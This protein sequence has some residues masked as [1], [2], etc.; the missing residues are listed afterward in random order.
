MTKARI[1][2]FILLSFAGGIA[3]RSFIEIPYAVLLLVFIVGFLAILAG[4]LRQKRQLWA[5][6]LMVLAVL[7]GIVRYDF[8]DYSQPVLGGL[9][10]KS[11]ILEGYVLREPAQSDKALNFSFRV[12]SLEGTRL[13]RPFLVRVTTRRFPEYAIGD[14]LLIRGVIR[15]PENLNGFDYAA[16]LKKD[17]IF[18]VVSFPDIEKKEGKRGNPI[19]LFLSSVKRAFEEKIDAVLPEPHG[20]LARGLLLGERESIPDDLKQ[21][22][23]RAGV[24]HIVALSGYNITIVGSFFLSFLLL[25]T[26]PFYWAF[27]IATSGIILFVILTGASPSV[28]RAGIMGILVLIAQ[29]EGRMYRMK[30]ALALAGALMLFHNPYVFRFDAAFELSFLAT[31]GLMVF[32]PRIEAWVRERFHQ[33][34][35]RIRGAPELR[36]EG[37]NIIF[38]T[39]AETIGAQVAV[40]PLLIVLFGRVSLISPV[41][42]IAVLLA[43]PYAMAASFVTGVLGFFSETLS[44]V[45]AFVSWAILE[46]MIRAIEFFAEFPYA[47]VEIPPGIAPFIAFGSLLAILFYFFT[48]FHGADNTTR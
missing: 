12:E 4:I 30:N 19:V 34:R 3:G 20:A 44:N 7:G 8:Y 22:F 16:Y 2:F 40:L 5:A 43:V 35:S 14:A 25:L 29:R 39:F 32:S 1:F 41:S 23:N 36:R 17:N 27:W 42:N 11:F 47:S 37:S 9:Y 28:T 6:G 31:I 13:D 10:G 45:S 33:L 15:E 46:Y 18:A 48:R 21:A 26:I 24:T 38:R